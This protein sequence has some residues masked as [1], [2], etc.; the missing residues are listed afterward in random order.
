MTNQGMATKGG[1]DNTH[2]DGQQLLTGI[3]IA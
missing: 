2:S 3:E 1:A